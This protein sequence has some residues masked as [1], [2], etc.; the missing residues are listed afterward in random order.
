MHVHCIDIKTFKKAS[1][2]YILIINGLKKEEFHL[3]H[4]FIM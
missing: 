3:N 1:Y 2:K 4:N